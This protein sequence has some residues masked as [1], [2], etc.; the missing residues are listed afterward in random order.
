MPGVEILED[1]GGGVMILYSRNVLPPPLLLRSYVG[2][3]I[4]RNFEIKGRKSTLICGSAVAHPSKPLAPKNEVR[5][6]IGMFA[7]FYEEIKVKGEIVTRYTCIT[8]M[9]PKL[10]RILK[11]LGAEKREGGKCME[12]SLDFILKLYRQDT[13]YE[14]LV[15]KIEAENVENEKLNIANTLRKVFTGSKAFL[16]VVSVAIL[17]QVLLP[18]VHTASTRTGKLPGTRPGFASASMGQSMSSRPAMKGM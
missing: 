18:K 13:S 17:F 8:A 15:H 2:Y 7:D 6:D 10:P 1:K 16:C 5:M 11:L 3:V 9:T 12:D 4:V 14:P